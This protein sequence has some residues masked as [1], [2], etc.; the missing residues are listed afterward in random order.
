M[1]STSAAQVRF[2]GSEPHHPSVSCHAVAVAHI[3]DLEGPTTKCITLYQGFGEE[4]TEREKDWQQ[5]LD[6]SIFPEKNKQKKLLWLLKKKKL[7]K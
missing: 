4:K 5:I 3:E 1:R 7:I 6:I 2:P